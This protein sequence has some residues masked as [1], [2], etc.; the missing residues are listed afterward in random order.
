RA[1]AYPSLLARRQKRRGGLTCARCHE[2]CVEV[3]L[4]S[5]A[6]II[7]SFLLQLVLSRRSHWSST[8]DLFY[9]GSGCRGLSP[10]SHRPRVMGCFLGENREGSLSV[11]VFMRGLTSLC[12][13]TACWSEDGNQG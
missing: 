13:S 5:P 11:V 9:P 2:I 10:T 12:V 8:E 6:C 4:L 1:I 3:R 7:A